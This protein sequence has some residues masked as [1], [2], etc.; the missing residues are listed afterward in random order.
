MQQTWHKPLSLARATPWPGPLDSLVR[1]P[2]RAILALV[3]ALGAAAPVTPQAV[4]AQLDAEAGKVTAATIAMLQEEEWGPPGLLA[5]QWRRYRQHVLLKRIV[6]RLG[7]SLWS[8]A[9]R[10]LKL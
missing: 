2:M 5:A 8:G 9:R 3:E 1:G 4:E 7:R 6:L 10:H